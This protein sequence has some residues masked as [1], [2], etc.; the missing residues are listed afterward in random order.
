MDPTV[1]RPLLGDRIEESPV[2]NLLSEL[3][4][5]C[6]LHAQP[7]QMELGE[8]TVSDIYDPDIDI[9][10]LT[11]HELTLWMPYKLD[12][13]MEHLPHSL[14]TEIPHC[15]D[16][17]EIVDEHSTVHFRFNVEHSKTRIV[18][19]SY[20]YLQIEL[21]TFEAYIHRSHDHFA[22]QEHESKA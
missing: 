9:E 14:F 12:T 21:P 19:T 4:L 20:N 6:Q 8:L 17:Y 1:N 7:L 2:D 22:E 5:H 3:D 11:F 18:P 13:L 10:D 16:R 15:Y